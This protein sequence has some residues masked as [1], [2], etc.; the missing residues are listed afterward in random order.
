[1]QRKGIK[2]LAPLVYCRQLQKSLSIKMCKEAQPCTLCIIFTLV[3]DL[4]ALCT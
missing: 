1:M 3:S 4:V 2:G